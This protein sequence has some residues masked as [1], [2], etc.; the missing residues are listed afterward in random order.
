MTEQAWRKKLSPEQFRVLRQG[1]T[2]R[3]FAGDY[4]NHAGE[5]LYRCAGCGAGL[6]SSAAKF[7]SGTGW[8]SFWAP[9]HT[10]R[11]ATA[12]DS[13]FGIVATEILCA[14]CGG[15]L[16]HVFTDGPQPTGLR[17]C[18]NSL[19]LQFKTKPETDTATFAAGCFWHV[20]DTYQKLDGVVAT[21]ADYT[22]GTTKNPTYKQV[23]SGKTGHTE[24]VEVVYDPAVI[25]YA[26]LLDVFWTLHDPTAPGR[27]PAD[28]RPHRYRAAAFT[29]GEEQAR[30]AAASRAALQESSKPGGQPVTTEIV[31]ATTFY[32]AEGY[33]QLH[34]MKQRL[35][36]R[37]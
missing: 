2:E 34:T 10:D 16:G 1:G 33:H 32:P 21:R 15:H 26:A 22:G 25:S 17:Y 18:V 36:R 4:W 24:A 9:V 20:Q 30:A 23:C 14:R 31:P 27:N 28:G 35:C 3:A 12:A 29:H 13:R 19:S 6:F 5:G 8:P 7:K 37:P 11:V